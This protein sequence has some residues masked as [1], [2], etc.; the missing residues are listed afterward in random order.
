VEIEAEISGTLQN[1][2]LAVRSNIGDAVASSLKK[3]VGEEVARAEQQVRAK[4]D[5]LGAEGRRQV[6]EKVAV[7]QTQF[8]DRV[9]QERQQLEQV[10]SELEAKVKEK[11]SGITGGIQLPG[12]IKLPN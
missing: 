8:Q 7:L 5:S 12:G 6:D 3:A 9:T 11:A 4:V 2:S 10:K 1:P